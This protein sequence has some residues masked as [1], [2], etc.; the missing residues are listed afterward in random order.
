MAF[1]RHHLLRTVIIACTAVLIAGSAVPECTAAAEALAD[2]R[3]H[4]AQDTVHLLYSSG[5]ITAL[6]SDRFE[7]DGPVTRE[8]FAQWLVRSLGGTPSP[9][10]PE[11]TDAHR[12]S[13]DTR[14]Y[15]GRA[16]ELGLLQGYPDGS[17]GPQ[18]TVTRA[19]MATILGRV[20][21]D[22]GVP[23]LPQRYFAVFE[24]R[25]QIPAWAEPAAAAVR[26]QLVV[27]RVAYRVFA[28]AD[29]TTRAE[30]ATMLHRFMPEVEEMDREGAFRIPDLTHQPSAPAPGYLVAGYY[31]GRD[32]YRGESYQTV[33]RFG[34]RINML[35]MSTGYGFQFN[36]QNELTIAGYDSEFLFSGASERDDQKV[37]V[38]ITN[39]FCPSIAD[40]IL[41]DPRMTQEA[42]DMIEQI[43]GRGYDGVNINFEDVRPR[44]RNALS[45]FMSAVWNR[46]QDRYI[47]TMAVPAKVRE[48]P[49]HGW[50]GAFDYPALQRSVHY[51]IPMAYD[52]HWSTAAPGPV[53]PVE[54]V[55]DVLRYTL[56]AVPAEKVLLGVPFYGYDWLDTAQPNR[57]RSV[58]WAQAQEMAINHGAPIE[59]STTW[60]AAP[61]FRYTDDDG[62]RRVVYF[63]NSQ[64]LEAKMK[65]VP[66]YGLAGVAFWR[67]GQ[68]APE[69]WS[70]IHRVLD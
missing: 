20:L 24:D 52:F 12:I 27:G 11:F 67:L 36:N 46:L 23:A 40:R 7:P 18:G 29:P 58:R 69:A 6:S 70:V 51:L 2:I 16:V 48:N 68:E 4:W 21:V 9:A 34:S 53:A 14:G 44:D 32:E 63:E 25:D 5:V 57:A 35:I 1:H 50:S 54:W 62:Q 65:L 49:E 22:L 41:N 61:F 42:V 55:E 38:R 66:E 17:F 28:P 59:W 13:V 45:A 15:V 64:S 39:S 10:P 19:E 60:T 26:R 37:L 47:V 56:S 8:V 31:L 3:G 30:A 33:E 43:L